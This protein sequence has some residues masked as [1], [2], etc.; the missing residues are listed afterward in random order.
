MKF[1]LDEN[2]PAELLDDLRAAGH[3]ADSVPGEQLAGAPDAVLL[4][5]VTN[6]AR[7][8]LTMDKGIGDVRASPPHLH[9]GIVLLRPPSSGRG[10]ALAFVR[11]HLLL[12][13]ERCQPGRLPV[14]T[15]RGVRIR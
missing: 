13:L 1:K 6:E 5:R 4:D 15:E 10:T 3:E 12:I 9:A 14:V 11:R 8:L 7:V 2:L